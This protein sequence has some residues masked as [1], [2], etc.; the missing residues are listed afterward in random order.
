MNKIKQ[1]KIPVSIINENNEI[2]NYR[3]FNYKLVKENDKSIRYGN[4]ILYLEWDPPE[5][6]SGL[7][8]KHY[9]IE[10]GRSLML[11]T[12]VTTPI[13]EIIEKEEEYIRFKT[14]NSIYQLFKTK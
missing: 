3:D 2:I 6:G 4:N 8:E 9:L 5:K 1:I 10:I 7:K 12:W 14:E 13:T 11:D